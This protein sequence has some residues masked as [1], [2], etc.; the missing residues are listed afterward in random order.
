MVRPVAHLIA[1]AV[2]PVQ[3]P[4]DPLIDPL[5]VMQP[6]GLVELQGVKP[7]ADVTMAEVRLPK[8]TYRTVPPAV[9]E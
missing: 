1:V 7:S 4:D 9:F 2:L 3:E 5:A 6:L 8:P